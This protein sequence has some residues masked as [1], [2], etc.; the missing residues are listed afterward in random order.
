MR[1]KSLQNLPTQTALALLMLFFFALYPS[2]IIAQ[3]DTPTPPQTDFERPVQSL[4]AI[5]L[6]A[7]QTGWTPELHQEAGDLLAVVGDLPGA[8][9]HW[10]LAADPDPTR[11]RQLTDAYITLGMWSEA[12]S[13]LT[14]MTQ[15]PSSDPWATFTLGSILAAS[16]PLRSITLLE[17]AVTDDAYTV[18]AAT[19]LDVIQADPA[20]PEISFQVGLTFLD[21]GRWT[22]AERAF[23]HAVTLGTRSA[24][25][26]A[27]VAYTRHR[28]NKSADEWFTNAFRDDPAAATPHYLFGL[29]LRE[30]NRPDESVDAFVEAVRLAPDNPAFYAE[31]GT[32]HQLVANYDEAEH[33]LKVAV[34]VA[35]GAAEFQT[36]LASFYAQEGVNLSNLDLRTIQGAAQSLPPDP[37]LI[38]GMGW[39]VYQSGDVTGGLA[40]IDQALNLQADHPA[41]THYRAQ[42]LIDSGNL[43]GAEPLVER[44]ANGTSEYASWA[45]GLLPSLQAPDASAP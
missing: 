16:D 17:T 19:I 39:L 40:Y 42:I 1:C 23:Q 9:R 5:Q 6:Q 4:Y 44:L 3:D 15:Q 11:Q 21:L 33:W 12:V 27:Y 41:A 36:M 29:Y 34:D 37:E 45:Q 31:L 18:E 25:S 35:N 8:V 28:Q 32:A 26:S 22:L 13:T 43:S 38:A 30:T 2:G 24:E 10:A 20:D 7:S 14:T